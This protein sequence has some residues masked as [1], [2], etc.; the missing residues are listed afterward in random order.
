M[1][2]KAKTKA[3]WPVVDGKPVEPYEIPDDPARTAAALADWERREARR[4]ELA[5]T[6]TSRVLNGVVNSI[7][8]RKGKGFELTL[9]RR[10]TFEFHRLSTNPPGKKYRIELYRPRKW[11]LN[12]EFWREQPK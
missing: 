9:L 4:A 7:H 2:T 11:D 1:R 8:V 3:N 6:L 10:W 12:I 5:R